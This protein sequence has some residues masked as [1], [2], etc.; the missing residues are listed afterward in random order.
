[1]SLDKALQ[2]LK[3]DVR[4]QEFSMKQGRYTKQELEQFIQNLPDCSDNAESVNLENQDDNSDA[5]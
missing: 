1:M 2:A 4:L 5:H 3:F